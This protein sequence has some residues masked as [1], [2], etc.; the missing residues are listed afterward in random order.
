MQKT[1]SW[2]F[3]VRMMMRMALPK[4][5]EQVAP[6]QLGVVTKKRPA[7]EKRHNSINVCYDDG[8]EK[9]GYD[10]PSNR[11]QLL[12]QMRFP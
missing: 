12:T 2:H 1:E 4:F 9:S 10:T 8:E 5:S 3:D 11:M 6:Y 7:T